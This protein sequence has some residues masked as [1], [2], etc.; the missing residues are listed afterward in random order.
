MQ[1]IKVGVVGCGK[2]SGA[3]FKRLPQFGI[4]E[5]DADWKVV[6]FQEKPANPKTISGD[7]DHCLVNMG[8]YVFDT[9]SLVREL[10]HDVKAPD[11][12]HDFGRNIIPA[13]VARGEVYAHPFRDPDTGRPWYWRDIGTLD[14]YYEANMEL[15]GRKPQFDLYDPNWHFR[16]WQPPLPPSKT[17]HGVTE[18]R[19][20]VV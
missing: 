9:E 5:V 6:G 11:S 20:S 3:Y 16:A 17:V 8:V 10:C 13:M 19:K 18:D 4:L 2:I 15:T 1:K 14:S 7:P 12:R